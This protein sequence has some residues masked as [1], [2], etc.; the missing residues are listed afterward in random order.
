MQSNYGNTPLHVA[1]AHGHLDIVDILLSAGA[2]V[3][4]TNDS[5]QMPAHE[6]TSNQVLSLLNKNRY[7]KMHL[8]K[9]LR[10]G[11]LVHLAVRAVNSLRKPN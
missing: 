9:K 2:D 5:R 11:V 3:N 8:I 7:I 4:I 10:V 1:C 6:A